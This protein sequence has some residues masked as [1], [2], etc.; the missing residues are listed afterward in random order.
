MTAG[1]RLLRRQPAKA[2]AVVRA[3]LGLPFRRAASGR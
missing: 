2:A 1:R 3:S